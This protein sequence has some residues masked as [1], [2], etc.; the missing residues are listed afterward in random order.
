MVNFFPSFFFKTTEI[1]ECKEKYSYFT[2]LDN[3]V[4]SRQRQMSKLFD[5]LM[6]WN[7]PH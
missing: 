2:T 6:T 5:E 1:V 3:N 4:I 7:F